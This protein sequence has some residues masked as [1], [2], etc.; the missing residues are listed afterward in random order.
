MKAEIHDDQNIVCFFPLIQ[1]FFLQFQLPRVQKYEMENSRYK[2]S[3]SLKL[4]AV[5][6]SMKRTC[7]V[8]L[9]LTWDVSCPFIQCIH[10]VYT[11]I[12]LL[13]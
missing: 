12:P 7:T 1:S 10:A 6:S 9:H 3:I 5:L 11:T 4:Q 13:T 2:L 8:L